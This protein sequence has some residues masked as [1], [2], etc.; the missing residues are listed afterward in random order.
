MVSKPNPNA[1]W[2]IY[3]VTNS[4]PILDAIMRSIPQRGGDFT[5]YEW[6]TVTAADHYYIQRRTKYGVTE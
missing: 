6:R 1:A 2:H 3:F 5:H 4:K